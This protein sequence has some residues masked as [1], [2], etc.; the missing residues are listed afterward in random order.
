MGDAAEQERIA[1]EYQESTAR[2]RGQRDGVVVTPVEV[3]DFMNRAVREL[4]AAHF[5]VTVGDSRVSVLDPFTGTG[6]FPA[7]MI[8][9]TPP[10]DVRELVQGLEAWELHP[11][12]A[13]VAQTNLDNV[14]QDA[15]V[16]APNVRVVDTFTVGEKPDTPTD[17]QIIVFLRDMG[18][19]I[20]TGTTDGQA[21]IVKATRALLMDHWGTK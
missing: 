5:Q 6:I 7:R 21:Q 14:T 10:E 11:G 20:T 18:R 13:R 19:D 12:A 2:D 17:D 9:T 4:L 15:G 1:R 16:P 3:V 8:Q